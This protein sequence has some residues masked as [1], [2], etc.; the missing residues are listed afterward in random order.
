MATR[1]LTPEDAPAIAEL[2]RVNRAFLAPWQPRRSDAY[3]TD[4]VQDRAARRAL[5]QYEL[6][7]SV[8]LVILDEDSRTVGAVTLQSVIRGFLQ[9]CS[10]GYWLAE[11]AQGRGLA[12]AAV[13]DAV[14]LAFEQLRLHR[15]QAET[16]VA[17]LRSQRVLERSGFLRCGRAPDFVMIDG[18]WRECLLYQRITPRPDLVQVPE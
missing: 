4:E 1:L 18:A 16:L 8:P 10:V 17:N 6:G 7:N 9:S 5:E 12:T 14:R 15:V 2:L 13:A 3:F 11:D